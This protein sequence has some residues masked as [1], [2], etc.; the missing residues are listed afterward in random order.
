[1]I[2]IDMLFPA[3]HYHSL[4][5]LLDLGAIGILA[6]NLAMGYSTAPYKDRFLRQHSLELLALIPLWGM[7]RLAEYDYLLL[8]LFRTSS[9]FGAFEN[10]GYLMSMFKYRIS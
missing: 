2:A 1:V 5:M 8:R 3:H 7:L 10:V 4:L 6:A 9:H